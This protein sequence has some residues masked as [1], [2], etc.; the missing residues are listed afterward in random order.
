MAIRSTSI[1]LICCLLG[2]PIG[3]EA[4]KDEYASIIAAVSDE[5][6]ISTVFDY[7]ES[8]A[9]DCVA[10]LNV[11]GEIA[12][13]ETVEV[14]TFVLGKLAVPELEQ[15]ALLDV[16]DARMDQVDDAYANEF[17]MSRVVDIYE[18]ETNAVIILP[19]CGVV[20]S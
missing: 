3:A 4:T 12:D 14:L 8:K 9:V 17:L 18:T 1:A 5:V 13:R 2:A 20:G 19:G 7:I 6:L 16:L 11:G 10:T 15:E